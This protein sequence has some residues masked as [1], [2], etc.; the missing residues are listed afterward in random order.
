MTGWERLGGVPR[1]RL[2]AA[3]AQL[4]LAAQPAAAVGKLLLPHQPD[5]GEQSFSWAAGDR[6][7]AQGTVTGRSPATP[8][9]AALRPSP[10]AL[11]LLGAPGVPGAIGAIGAPDSGG[12]GGGILRE[13]PLGGRTLGEAY[14]WLAAQ[15]ADL[16]GAGLPGEI[17]RPAGLS[18]LSGHPLADGA[19]FDAGDAAAFAELGSLFANADRALAAWAAAWPGASAVRCWPH[20]FD[21]ATLA[22]IAPATLAAA[23]PEQA[24]TIGAGMV[25]GDVGRGGRGEPYFYVSPWPY[26]ES[27]EWPPLPGGG[28]WNM[29]GW[30]GAVLEAPQFMD[31]DRAADQ[32]AAVENF[33]RS[34]AA[35]CHRLLG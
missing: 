31:A 13:L 20:H 5:Y 9:R 15:L 14:E 25:P 6:C 27:A 1:A 28:T 35:A 4:H 2:A 26:P 22:P 29:E 3:R 11:L 10:P 32:A 12:G 17:E 8:F 33:L 34:A 24:R 30:L 23:P 7:L 19:R 21:I 16:L 18:D